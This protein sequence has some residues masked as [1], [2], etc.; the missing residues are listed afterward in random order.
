[1]S[2]ETRMGG[3]GIR[4]GTVGVSHGQPEQA[5][6]LRYKVGCCACSFVCPVLAI[7]PC[8]P[9]AS[10][11]RRPHVGGLQQISRLDRPDTASP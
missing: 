10:P 4:P 7:A 11:V 8:L 6:L 9:R 3:L 5:L 2:A 1:M